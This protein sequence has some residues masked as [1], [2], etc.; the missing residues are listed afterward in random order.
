[1][2]PRSD[3]LKAVLSGT[4]CLLLCACGGAR[5]HPASDGANAGGGVSHN[6]SSGAGPSVSSPAPTP[7]PTRAQTLAFVRAVNLSA[8]DI[9]EASV[10]VKRHHTETASERREEQD[11]ETV[12]GMGHPRT[13]AKASSPKLKR[14]QELEIE[15]ITSSVT[16]LSR[17]QAVAR[18][19]VALGAPALR[20]CFARV[21]TRNLDDKQLRDAR[22]GHVTVSKLPVHAAGST[23]TV[24]LRVV[25]ELTLPFSEVSVP[26]Y[27][28]ELGFAIGRAEVGL[29]AASITQP[30][31]ATTEQELLALLLARA[32][33]HPL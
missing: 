11:C 18:Q 2:K 33:A 13:L 16:V 27:V 20:K 5:T 26:I 7:V 30:I 12:A 6:A 17:E 8:Q 19:F 21:L 29:T 23:A 28:D 4:T 32:R 14:G 9:P 31:P 3:Y 1:M 10:E 24:G 22:W 15:R 25:A